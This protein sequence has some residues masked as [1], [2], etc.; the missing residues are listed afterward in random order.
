MIETIVVLTM[1]GGLIKLASTYKTNQPISVAEE[2]SQEIIPQNS[3]VFM[4]SPAEEEDDYGI[5]L[6]VKEF[7]ET[8]KKNK[9]INALDKHKRHMAKEDRNIS[10]RTEIGQLHQMNLEQ[11]FPNTKKYAQTTN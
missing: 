8:R 2:S 10:F 1:I 3:F 6:L 11:H 4:D 9:K 7:N 5:P